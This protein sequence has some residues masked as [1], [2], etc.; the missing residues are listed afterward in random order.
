MPEMRLRLSMNTTRMRL[1]AR[2]L[3]AHRIAVITASTAESFQLMVARM[4]N[5]PTILMPQMMAYS[6]P[7][8]AASQ[9][10]NRSETT[11]LMR[12]PVLWRSKY[13]KLKR[14]YWSNR[15]WRMWLSMRA[16]MTWPQ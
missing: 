13:E 12:S 15:S 2:E 1:F 11:R 9:M 6:G 3:Y 14:S 8:C 16:P 7:W 4:A 5:E 10:S